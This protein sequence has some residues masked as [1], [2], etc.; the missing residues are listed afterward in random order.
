MEGAGGGGGGELGSA[1]AGVAKKNAGVNVQKNRAV[2]SERAVDAADGMRRERRMWCVFASVAIRPRC[3]G[4]P[5]FS[6]Q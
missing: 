4:N 1:G 6:A 5:K 2:A 3:S